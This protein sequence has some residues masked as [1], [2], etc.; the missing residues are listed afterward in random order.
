[1]EKNIFLNKTAFNNNTVIEQQV[2]IAHLT[3]DTLLKQRS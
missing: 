1:V 3:L 2:T